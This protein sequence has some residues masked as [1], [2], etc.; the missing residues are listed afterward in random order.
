[1]DWTHF[2]YVFQSSPVPSRQLHH[3][4]LES[5]FRGIAG[6][7][8]GH[9]DGLVI[10]RHKGRDARFRGLASDIGEDA[11]DELVVKVLDRRIN[12]QEV[13]CPLA[14]LGLVERAWRRTQC[15]LTG[16]AT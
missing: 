16:D 6:H 15:E 4:S 12:G 7:G 11:G 5:L 13:V 1:M 8:L 3:L 14:E 2:G 10:C 9:Y